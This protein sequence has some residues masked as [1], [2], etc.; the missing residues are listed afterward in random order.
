MIPRPPSCAE[1]SRTNLFSLKIDI[2]ITPCF[3]EEALKIIFSYHFSHFGGYEADY[4]EMKGYN[5]HILQ[6][7]CFSMKRKAV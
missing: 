5:A 7:S 3:M 2:L 4:S 1:K 6:N